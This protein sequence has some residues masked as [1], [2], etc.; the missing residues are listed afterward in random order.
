MKKIINFLKFNLLYLF[1]IAPSFVYAS[2]STGMPWESPLSKLVNSIT[3]PVAFGLSALSIV[4][5]F[6]GMAFGVELEG[7]MKKLAI[8]AIVIAVI[9]FAINLLSSLFGISSTIIQ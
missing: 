5:V 6:A 3:G 7:L 1:F 2:S 9:V 8:T 4:G